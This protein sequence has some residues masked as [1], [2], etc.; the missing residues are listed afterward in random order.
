MGGNDL[1]KAEKLFRRGK[2]TQVLQLLEAQIFRYRQVYRFY[3]ILGMSCLHTGDFSGA[4][5]FL[6]RALSIR[7]GSVNT[8]LG[9]GVVHLKQQK[10]S[11][12]LQDWFEVIDQDPKNKY[13]RR[14][15]DAVKKYGDPDRLVEFI[16]G[17]QIERLIPGKNKLSPGKI[18]LL[19]TVVL[20]GTAFLLFPLYSSFFSSFS[21]T[22]QRNELSTMDLHVDV[23]KA[24]ENSDTPVPSYDM[25]SSELRKTY[26]RIIDYF[27]NYEDNR[28]QLE[29]NR[30]RRSNASEEL[31]MKVG[32][33][34]GYIRTPSFDTFSHNYPF[35]EVRKEPPLYDGCFVIWRGKVSNL[36]IGSDLIQFDLLV[37]YENEK[38]L[39]GIVPVH[40]DFAGKVNPAHPI[41]VLG[42]IRI[43]ND[44]ILLDAVSIHH[45]LEKG[46]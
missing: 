2:Y 42:R 7:P 6:Q 16:E 18:T 11:E 41:E 32:L 33:L 19:I 35:N 22:T 30:I 17:K 40:M 43:E 31:K 24:Q 5:S 1:K 12:A 38:T 25:T 13:A 46:D 36:I 23:Y 29:I 44:A 26:E 39:E 8:L 10:T 9:L 37:G 15:L 3:H 20:I 14:G 34:E 4:A 27:N 21:I 45:F 28:A